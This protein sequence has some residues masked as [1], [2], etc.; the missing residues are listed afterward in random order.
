MKI[1]MTA[2]ANI[3]PSFNVYG[4]FSMRMCSAFHAVSSS[5]KAAGIAPESGILLR[6]NSVQQS[7]RLSYDEAQ[8]VERAVS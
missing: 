8:R 6:S 7:N 4:G 2:A 3:P 1:A 5:Q